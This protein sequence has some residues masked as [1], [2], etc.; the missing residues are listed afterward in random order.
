[1]ELCIYNSINLKRCNGCTNS[2]SEPINNCRC[3]KIYVFD[4]STVLR[5]ADD[6]TFNMWMNKYGVQ[7]AYRLPVDAYTL[8]ADD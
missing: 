7:S 4:P 6:P 8:D 3:F 2:N 1:M 5:Y